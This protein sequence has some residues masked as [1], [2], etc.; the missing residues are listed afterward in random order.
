MVE[1]FWHIV[2]ELSIMDWSAVRVSFKNRL[3]LLAWLETKHLVV[4]LREHANAVLSP[5]WHYKNW[6]WCSVVVA[7]VLGIVL[8]LSEA[9]ALHIEEWDD[10]IW[11]IIFVFFTKLGEDH[12]WW[13]NLLPLLIAV[14]ENHE[15]LLLL[16]IDEDNEWLCCWWLLGVLHI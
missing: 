8:V 2:S 4:I 15:L 9:L 14:F 13:L 5:L 7:E 3:G 16:L 1:S 11:E 12:L 10:N 6:D